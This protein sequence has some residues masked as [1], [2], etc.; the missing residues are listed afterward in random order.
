MAFEVLTGNWDGLWNGNNYYLYYNPQISKFQYFRHDLEMSFGMWETFYP[1]SETPIYTWGDGGRGYRLI[2][3][4]LSVEPFKSQF[5]QYSF[6]LLESYFFIGGNFLERMNFLNLE[7]QN[8]I[9]LDIWRQ[10]DFGW[11]FD[12]FKDFPEKGI[13]RKTGGFYPASGYPEVWSMGL[14]EYMDIRITSAY[15]Q[16]IP[17]S[18]PSSS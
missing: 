5:S 12:E 1:M 11:S 13:V 7:L 15:Q 2:N 8:A 17:P 18:P 4:I 3:R 10:T 16:L 9:K 6:D 14:K